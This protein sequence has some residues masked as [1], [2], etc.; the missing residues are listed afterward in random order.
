MSEPN[1]TN[2]QSVEANETFE[3][4]EKLDFSGVNTSAS[5][6]DQVKHNQARYQALEAL[7]EFAA[8]NGKLDPPELAMEVKK[9][10]KVFF[11]TASDALS[12]DELC[13]AEAEL[14]KLYAT[15]TELVN[16]VNILTLQTT[17]EDRRVH[18]PWWL[19]VFLGSGSVGRNFFRQLFWVAVILMGLIFLRKYTS[20]AIEETGGKDSLSFIDPFLYGALGA[21][22]Y[23][24]KNLTDLYT[25]RAL[26]P[27]KLSTNWLRL[28]MGAL[29]GGLIVHLFWPFIEKMIPN[30]S[31]GVTQ[32]AIGF[33]AGYSV[34]F[35]YRLLDRFTQTITP[36]EMAE[37]SSIPTT[38]R[39]AQIDILTK[40][41]KE[42]TDEQD[43]AA[44]RRLLEKL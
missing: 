34:N 44:I 8:E 35:F 9:L 28:F 27:K 15:L 29:A 39:Q 14:E 26:H 43:K 10:K 1:Q 3:P 37:S 16:P 19:A 4:R 7:L 5:A 23:L 42:M 38:P 17:S 22:F 12:V 33:L 36:K 21:W 41:L 31:I 18:R 30:E 20:L 2:Q 40:R 24:Y 32:G 6:S 11:Y 25:N 13:H